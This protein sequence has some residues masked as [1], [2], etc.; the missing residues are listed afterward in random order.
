MKPDTERGFYLAPE[1]M[2]TRREADRLGAAAEL[3]KQ[4]QDSREIENGNR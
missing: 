2:G 1:L 3:M 4:L